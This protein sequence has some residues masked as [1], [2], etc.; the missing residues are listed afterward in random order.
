VNVLRDAVDEQ[1]G[2]AIDLRGRMERLWPRV[3]QP[4]SVM[5]NPPLYVQLEPVEVQWVRPRL[6]PG[7]FTFGLGVSARVRSYLGAPP[8]TPTIPPLPA[9]REVESMGNSFHLQ[10]PVQVPFTELTA[11]ARAEL[12]GS[13][14]VLDSG[15]SIRIESVELRGASDGRV[16][17]LCGINARKGI[18]RSANGVLHMIGVPRY[19]PVTRM[20]RFEEVAY[21]LDTRNVLLRMANW[22]MHDDFLA[23]VQAALEFEM[24]STLD[25]ALAAANESARDIEV[26]EQLTLH[27]QLAALDIGPIL[28]SDQA[29]I[30]VG[31]ASGTVAADVSLFGQAQEAP[32]AD[33]RH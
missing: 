32:P 13:E 2:E 9:L 10:V 5:D 23:G 25:M 19:D 7:R 15:A 17:I 11:R 12:V 20:L 16:H 22:A 24:G 6:E 26:S 29:I 28:V 31:M 21:D 30:I 14:R 4:I 8:T 1:L 33:T 3:L 27:V 18:L